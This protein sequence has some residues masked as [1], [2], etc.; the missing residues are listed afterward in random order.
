VVP[1]ADEGM[2]WQRCWAIDSNVGG[3]VMVAEEAEGQ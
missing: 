3:V 1:V 2:E